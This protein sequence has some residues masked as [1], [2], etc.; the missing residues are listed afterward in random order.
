MPVIGLWHFKSVFKTILNIRTEFQ[1]VISLWYLKIALLQY[2]VWNIRTDYEYPPLPVIEYTRRVGRLWIPVN[3]SLRVVPEGLE[4]FVEWIAGL[5]SVKQKIA[6]W[7]IYLYLTQ[8]SSYLRCFSLM[9]V[10]TPMQCR[11]T[12]ISKTLI[13][14]T[15]F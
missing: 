3:E 10:S 11:L 12:V 6:A 14:S 15:F 8:V 7:E 2:K 9:S 4:D 13:N 5:L 1:S